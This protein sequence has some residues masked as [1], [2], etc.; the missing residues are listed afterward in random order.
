MPSVIARSKR[1]PVVSVDSGMP[2]G[3]LLERERSSH[4]KKPQSFLY[5]W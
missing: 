5:S 3:F 2:T 4:V 1:E